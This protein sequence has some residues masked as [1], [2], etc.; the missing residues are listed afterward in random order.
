[1]SKAVKL[2][3]AYVIGTYSIR[4]IRRILVRDGWHGDRLEHFLADAI[5]TRHTHS[6]GAQ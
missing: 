4:E 2:R 3:R 5:A 6:D 1:M